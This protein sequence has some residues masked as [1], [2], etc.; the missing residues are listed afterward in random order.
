ML[1]SGRPLPT[2]PQLCSSTLGGG[3]G[4]GGAGQ[5]LGGA[6]QALGGRAPSKDSRADLLQQEDLLTEKKLTSK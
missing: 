5:A 6:E 3:A 2:E 1:P 4:P